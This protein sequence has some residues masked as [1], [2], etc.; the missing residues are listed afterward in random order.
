MINKVH[1]YT[2]TGIKLLRHT[3]AIYLFSKQNVGTPISLQVAPTSRCN[4]QCSFCS[5]VNRDKHEDLEYE[6]V[7]SLVSKLSK[8][9]LKTVEWT[10]G[11]DPTLWEP[12]NEAIKYCNR[13]GLKQGFI[14]NGVQLNE[15]IREMPLIYLTWIRISMNCLDYVKEINIPEFGGTLGFSYVLKGWQDIGTLEKIKKYAEDHKVKYVRLVPNCQAT[16]EE[17]QENNEHLPTIADRMGEP[18][19]Y[20]KKEFKRPQ[21]CY[22][23]YFK[24]FLLHD[25][26]VYPCSSVVLNDNADRQF[27]SKYRWV[28]M[29]R[30]VAQYSNTV[31]SFPTDNCDHCVFFKQNDLLTNLLEL[32]GMEDFV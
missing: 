32:N 14:T 19:F 27:H 12:I 22:W 24:P 18:F 20:Q 17:Q 31:N 7:I 29:E 25:G 9:G 13:L 16:D 3:D 23:C 2:S 4:L 5:N 6:E 26:Y 11:G 21:K 30:L 15:K 28:P 1:T 10:G 8:I